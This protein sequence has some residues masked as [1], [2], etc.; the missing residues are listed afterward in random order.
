MP[1]GPSLITDNKTTTC[2]IY[3]NLC[4]SQTYQCAGTVCARYTQTKDSVSRLGVYTLD[5]FTEG[6]YENLLHALH[7]LT[8]Q[9]YIGKIKKLII[10]ATF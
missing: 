1:I 2:R 5:P 8:K 3:F 9:L 4:R 7:I 10:V 6:M